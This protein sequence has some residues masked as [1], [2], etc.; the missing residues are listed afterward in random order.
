MTRRG[1]AIVNSWCEI[2]FGR[3]SRSS[4]DPPPRPNRVWS[5]PFPNLGY[6][7][8][9]SPADGRNYMPRPAEAEA[10]AAASGSRPPA[11][12]ARP[13]RV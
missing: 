3:Q 8:A 5:L 7:S 4:A 9:G 1:G 11:R 13:C 12:A 6:R 10:P 2:L